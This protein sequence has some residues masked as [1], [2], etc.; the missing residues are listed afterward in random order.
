MRNRR[1]RIGKLV[2]GG[3]CALLPN[4]HFK[5]QASRLRAC[6]P[7]ASAH[8]D[9]LRDF[10]REVLREVLK[11]QVKDKA[12]L[13]AIE[14]TCAL[15]S[16]TLRS[17]PVQED[18]RMKYGTFNILGIAGS[19]RPRSHSRA[20]LHAAS[21]LL[22]PDVLLSIFELDGFAAIHSSRS[23]SRASPC[24]AEL[25]QRVRDADAVL[26]AVPEYLHGLLNLL[27]CALELVVHPWHENPWAGKHA[28]V[29]GATEAP[30]GSTR[31]QFHF[32]RTLLD[33][34]MR[35]VDQ[36][37][38]LICD[39]RHAFDLDG[40]ALDPALRLQLRAL[41]QSLVEQQQS[42]PNTQTVPASRPATTPPAGLQ[43]IHQQPRSG[44]QE[45]RTR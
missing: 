41:L 16:P 20:C 35:P 31:A 32:H 15:I 42:S 8:N 33:M 22:P 25:K 44:L 37:A 3:A 7:Y 11:E 4:R 12:S 13:F 45:S 5:I 2:E 43:H 17:C 6:S 28:A 10:L 14:Q 19:V 9:G 23:A 24:V 18:T 30:N 34:G 21:Q 29:I 40:G 36:P 38:V 39:A 26:F 27:D 1:R